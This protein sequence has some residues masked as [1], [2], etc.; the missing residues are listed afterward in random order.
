MTFPAELMNRIYLSLG[1]NVEKEQ[2]LPR[3]VAL[4]ATRARLVAVSSVYETAPVGNVDAPAYFNAAALVETTRTPEDFKREI[5]RP[6]E[7]ALGRR[8]SSDKNAPRTI[9]IDV[10]LVNEQI[11]ELDGRH[12][13]EPDVVAYPHVAIPLAEIA[14]D[15]IHPETRQTLADIASRFRRRGGIVRVREIDLRSHLRP[16]EVG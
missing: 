11:C 12:V 1:S 3:A 9:D 15:Y 14:P 13:P 8:R 4:L 2:N 6:I 5:L 10:A 7:S 16:A